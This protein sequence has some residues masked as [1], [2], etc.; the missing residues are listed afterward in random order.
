MVA[1]VLLV[2]AGI[3]SAIEGG[4]GELVFG[5]V[6]TLLRIP[7]GC[8]KEAIL[9]DLRT[10]L[11]AELLSAVSATVEIDR[12]VGMVGVDFART[13]LGDIPDLTGCEGVR[14]A[15]LEGVCD[16]DGWRAMPEKGNKPLRDLKP[17]F[18]GGIAERGV[19]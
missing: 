17:W 13:A 19:E 1:L 12:N 5:L 10:S 8:G 3:F 4:T 9:I 14:R 2:R 15:S 7:G 18:G 16:P 11:S 6:A